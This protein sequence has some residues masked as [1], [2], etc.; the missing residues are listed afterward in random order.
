MVQFFRNRTFYKWLGLAG[1]SV[2]TVYGYYEINTFGDDFRHKFA[3]RSEK[4]RLSP[5]T[6]LKYEVYDIIARTG[7]VIGDSRERILATMNSDD[8][9]ERNKI[10]LRL[11]K[12]IDDLEE[13]ISS[14]EKKY[15]LSRIRKSKLAHGLARLKDYNSEFL[16]DLYEFTEEE[17]SERI[18]DILIKIF[19]T[20]PS[21]DR[22]RDEDLFTPCVKYFQEQ[23]L[24]ELMDIRNWENDDANSMEHDILLPPSVEVSENVADVMLLKAL[25]RHADI[26][27]NM[28]HVAVED[29]LKLLIRLME[30]KFDSVELSREATLIA[31]RTIAN[32]ALDDRYVPTMIDLGFHKMLRKVVDKKIEAAESVDDYSCAIQS[33]LHA[34]RALSNLDRDDEFQRPLEDGVFLI[35]PVYRPDKDIEK[36][37]VFVHGLGGSIG[38]TW[39]TMQENQNQE[40]APDVPCNWLCEWS[41]RDLQRNPKKCRILG[42][43]YETAILFS[44][45]QCPYDLE[46]RSLQERAKTIGEKLIKAGV[47]ERPVVFVCYSLGGLVVKQILKTF[48]QMQ[49]NTKGVIFLSTPHLGSPVAEVASN[50]DMYSYLAKVVKTVVSPEVL[51][52]GGTGSDL[53]GLNTFFK[54]MTEEKKIKVL[55][56]TEELPSNWGLK[57]HIVPPERGDPGFG[58]VRSSKKIMMAWLLLLMK[59]IHCI[60]TASILYAIVYKTNQTDATETI[61]KLPAV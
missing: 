19:E 10:L 26:R 16:N 15:L 34:V 8:V 42:I 2:G 18:S 45:H 24:Q 57:I 11:K 22:I 44:Q 27:E 21:L 12:E 4:H 1:A 28:S 35:D 52:L 50:E 36:D 31:M 32:L 38:G 59:W 17:R 23:A 43:E 9:D 55:S 14:S 41:V 53:V 51:L 47:G 33:R 46:T 49:D 25:R 37:V 54:H 6:R 58:E 56:W 13:T 5:L 40:G 7:I 39:T 20:L 3:L 30:P 48:P 61:Q 60:A 29:I